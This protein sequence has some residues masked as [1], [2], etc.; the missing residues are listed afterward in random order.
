MTEITNIA[1]KWLATLLKRT[2]EP[3]QYIA[4]FRTARGR[5]LALQKN[6]DA[7]Y[8]WTEHLDLPDSLTLRPK[9]NYSSTKSRSSNLNRKNTPRLIVGKPVD[10]WEL[11]TTDEL[12]TL[13]E[14]YQLQ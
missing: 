3:T 10:Y 12:K 6:R 5:E 13:V 11:E 1:E 7:I 2:A 9:R 4:G 14:W 8:I